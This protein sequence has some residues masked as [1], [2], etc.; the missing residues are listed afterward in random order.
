VLLLNT[1]LNE[2]PFNLA[3]KVGE[4]SAQVASLTSICKRSGASISVPTGA[5]LPDCGNSMTGNMLSVSPKRRLMI[6]A[7]RSQG[8]ARAPAK[9]AHG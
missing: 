4:A 9:V 7:T 3:D 5:G 8:R 1:S 6:S 2:V